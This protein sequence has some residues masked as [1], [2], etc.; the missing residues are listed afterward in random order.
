MTILNGF[1]L[2]VE[3]KEVRRQLIEQSMPAVLPDIVDT[4]H[5]APPPED[6]F[7]PRRLVVDGK[8]VEIGFETHRP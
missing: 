3:D 6:A 5:Q 1:Q 7:K 4:A 8:A 2:I